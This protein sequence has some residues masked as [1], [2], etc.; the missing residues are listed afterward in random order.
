MNGRLVALSLSA[1]LALAGC[2]SSAAGDAG[3]EHLATLTVHVGIFGGPERPDGGM[4]A[5]NAPAAN[6]PVVIADRSGVTERAKTD[7]DGVARFFVAPGR[8]LVRSPSC[9][10][11]R[12]QAVVVHGNH[13]AHLDI[14]CDV[15]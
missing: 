14:R 4:A 9:G 11:A 12:S 6:A 2:A 1:L 5:S 3:G 10:P 13:S 8:Y 7:A 15:P